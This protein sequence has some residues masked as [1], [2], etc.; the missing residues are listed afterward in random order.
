MELLPDGSIT[1]PKG[2]RASGIA[3]GIKKSGN[4]DLVLI[5]SD[6]PGACAATFTQNR[7]AAAPVLAGNT[8]VAVTRNGGVFGFSPE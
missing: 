6:A 7:V 1:S 5:V 4:P 8:V 3:A 2:F